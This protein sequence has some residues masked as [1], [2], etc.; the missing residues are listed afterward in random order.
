MRTNYEKYYE[1]S[2]YLQKLFSIKIV[3]TSRF[4]FLFF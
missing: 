1:E 2:L 4:N 3:L